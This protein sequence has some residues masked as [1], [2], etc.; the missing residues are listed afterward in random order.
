MAH[1]GIPSRKDGSQGNKDGTS[2]EIVPTTGTKPEVAT[3]EV[4]T[5][6]FTE[7]QSQQ[8]NLAILDGGSLLY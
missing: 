7:L 8:M 5:D 2:E 1:I 3:P 4:G 6:T